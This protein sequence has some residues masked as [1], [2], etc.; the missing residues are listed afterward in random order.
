MIIFVF[1][2]AAVAA[3]LIIEY[4]YEGLRQAT[5]TYNRDLGAY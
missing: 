5:S 4:I 3:L 1:A 2:I